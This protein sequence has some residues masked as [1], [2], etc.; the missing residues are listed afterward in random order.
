MQNL[1]RIRIA[2]TA[3][4]V[5]VGE[6]ALQCVICPAQRAGECGEA[7]LERFD[8]AGAQ[9]LQA[10]LARDYVERGA[11]L[12]PRF[13]EPQPSVIELER[14]PHISSAH[15]GSVTAPVQPAAH[16]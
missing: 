13:R 12:R 5:R 11:A 15:L 14:S 3:K 2:D 6:R 8:T 4:N 1:V 9:R 16:L 7:R 10:G